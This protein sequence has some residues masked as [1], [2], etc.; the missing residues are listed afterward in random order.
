MKLKIKLLMAGAGLLI[1]S[2]TNAQTWTA[3]GS[4]MYY[5]PTSGAVSIG[6][7]AAPAAGVK[8]E[9]ANGTLNIN[10]NALTFGANVFH[11]L[12]YNYNTFATFG[13]FLG[14]QIDGPVLYGYQGGALGSAQGTP[15]VTNRN[16]ALRWLHN[17]NVGIGENNPLAKLQISS[18][19]NAENVFDIT[20]NGTC[21]FRIKSNG[22]VYSRDVTVQATTFPDYVF[23]KEY[24]LMSLR[25]LNSF[26]KKNNHLPEMP[27]AA[28]VEK[29]GMSLSQINILLVQKVEE[30]TLYMIKLQEEVDQLKSQK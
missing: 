15:T 8:L 21:N 10:T 28:E 29:N 14:K 23:A 13:P 5:S 17:G 12:V 9:I 24:K 25:E 18:T 7:S 20:Y 26:I 11:G 6:S 27:T 2:A 19:V 22:Y 30:L 16:I 3:S 1:A 4:N